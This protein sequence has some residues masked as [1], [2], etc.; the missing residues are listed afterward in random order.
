ML[1]VVFTHTVAA[2]NFLVLTYTKTFL[3]IDKGEKPA[4]D[5]M[6]NFMETC[7]TLDFHA[8]VSSFDPLLTR[9]KVEIEGKT[10]FT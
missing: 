4:N 10:K 7:A 1:H 6:L 9:I 8:I 2:R 3:L 5:P